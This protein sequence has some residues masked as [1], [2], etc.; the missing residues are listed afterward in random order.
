MKLV[1]ITTAYSLY[2]KKFY[3]KN[4]KIK[5]E[6]YKKQ[7][8]ALDY[9]S[10]GLSDYWKNA[11]EPL[12]YSVTE[13]LANAEPLQKKWAEENGV[14]YSENNWLL[15]ITESQIIKESPD[16]LFIVDY[17]TFKYNWIKEIREKCPCIRLVLGWCGA[18]FND[19]TVFKAYDVVLSCIPE[20]VFQFQKM[21]HQSEHIH[22]AFDPRILDRINLENEAKIDFSFVG[23]IVRGNEFHIERERI[24]EE[25]VTKIDV[26]IFTSAAEVSLTEN[27]KAVL[28]GGLYDGVQILKK[29][30]FSKSTLLSIPIVKKVANWKARPVKQTNSKLKPYMRPA[31]FGIEM[32]QT[33]RN[34]KITFNNHI[35]ISPR[36]ASNMRLWEAT[37]VGTCLITDWKENI[38]DLYEVDKEIVTYRSAEECLEKAKWLLEHPIEREAIAKAGQTRCL[39]D[40][41]YAQRARK[42]DDIIRT[43]L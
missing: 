23:S 13:I 43:R 5:S 37:G 14:K 10:F 25:L 3:L 24:L 38:H 41:T 4:P 39:K 17:S 2:L 28:R 9:D 20:L 27:I 29:M 6:T 40:H 19:K 26:K 11:L 42:L 30:G 18:P 33:L 32:F 34:S 22:H 35:D 1:K 12:G 8:A 31:V 7:K 15:D 16:I 21:G 36:S